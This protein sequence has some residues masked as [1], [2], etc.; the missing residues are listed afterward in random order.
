[1]VPCE[2]YT[3]LCGFLGGVTG[4]NS[5]AGVEYYASSRSES[6]RGGSYGKL[7]EASSGFSYN[8]NSTKQ[9]VA[10]VIA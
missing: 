2:H 3:S 1:M 6:K 9:K 7:A 10:L 5:I 4:F 8:K